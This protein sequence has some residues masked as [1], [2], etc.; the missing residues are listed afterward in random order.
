M[1]RGDI[2]AV[3]AHCPGYR[4]A[5]CL[6]IGG[7]CLGVRRPPEVGDQPIL[8]VPADRD[9]LGPRRQALDRV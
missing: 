1:P 3:G 8:V 2:N 7:I 5:E 4:L 9:R 6:V